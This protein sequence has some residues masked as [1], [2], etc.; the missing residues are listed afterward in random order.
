MGAVAGH[1]VTKTRL[2]FSTPRAVISVNRVGS[3]SAALHCLGLPQHPFHGLPALATVSGVTPGV[4]AVR[5][6]PD[7]SS[8]RRIGV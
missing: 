8:Y 6:M 4:A 5:H 2:A 7:A 1:V 3:T